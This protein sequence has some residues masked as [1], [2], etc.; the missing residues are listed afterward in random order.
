MISRIIYSALEKA[1]VA[2]YW[3]QEWKSHIVCVPRNSPLNIQRIEFCLWPKLPT[4][5]RACKKYHLELINEILLFQ[6]SC[7][8]TSANGGI[9]YI[10]YS[11]LLRA[12]VAVYCVQVSKS[13]LVCVEKFPSEYS[14]NI[15]WLMS[16]IYHF[17]K[18]LQKYLLELI[19][20]ILLFQYSCGYISAKRGN[21]RIIY[22]A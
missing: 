5:A 14:N 10:I 17:C 3:G 21:C 13:H 6:Y 22:S 4:F 9:S 8:Y 11:A 18:G 19:N 16:K 20:E 12:W 1:L 7:G 15:L 2:V